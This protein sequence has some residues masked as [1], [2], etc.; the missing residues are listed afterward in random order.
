MFVELCSNPSPNVWQTLRPVLRKEGREEG[1]K[2]GRKGGRE[3]GRKE[4][5]KEGIPHC[6][7]AKKGSGRILLRKDR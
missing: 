5:R 1:R 7:Q 6:L 4:A 2:E 3:E